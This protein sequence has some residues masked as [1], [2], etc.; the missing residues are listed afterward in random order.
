MIQSDG[1]GGSLL[2]IKAVPGARR[3]AIA[4]VLGDRL[5]VRVAAPPERGRANRAIEALVARILGLKARDV[6]VASGLTSPDKTLHIRG[7]G[8]EVVEVALAGGAE[9]PNR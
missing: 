8:P 5:K 3:E 1:E 2:R 6:C 9:P 7:C 4:G